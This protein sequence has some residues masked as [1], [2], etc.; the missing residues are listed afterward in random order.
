MGTFPWSR[1]RSLSIQAAVAYELSR[2]RSVP[3]RGPMRSNEYRT[4][5]LLPGPHS[6][7]KSMAVESGVPGL[8]CP[9]TFQVAVCVGGLQV[10]P[11]WE[12]EEG[13]EDPLAVLLCTSAHL[14]ICR[15]QMFGI[16][17]HLTSP[18]RRRVRPPCQARD[19]VP[20]KSWQTPRLNHILTANAEQAWAR[21]I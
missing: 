12:D 19:I 5:S 13:V 8:L 7:D 18:G 6:L 20:V 14:H 15:T 1:A 3:A 2:S 17:G 21:W 16:S 9:R 11:L 4:V 10:V